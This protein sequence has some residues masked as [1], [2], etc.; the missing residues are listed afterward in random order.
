MEYTGAA[1]TVCQLKLIEMFINKILLIQQW[2]CD[3]GIA[4]HML[5]AFQ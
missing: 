2:L 5:A 4:F 3:N 1:E